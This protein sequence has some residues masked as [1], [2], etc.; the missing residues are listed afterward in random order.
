MPAYLTVKTVLPYYSIM[1]PATTGES[2]L[3]ADIIDTSDDDDT[4]SRQPASASCAST[5]D[6]SLSRDSQKVSRPSPRQFSQQGGVG[7]S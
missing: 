4:A 1:S 6:V 7:A 2:A 3:P 5:H